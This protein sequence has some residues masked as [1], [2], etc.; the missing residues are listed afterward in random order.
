MTKSEATRQVAGPVEP[1]SA[2][3]AER[4]AP[5]CALGR[6][7]WKLRAWSVSSM[8]RSLCAGSRSER[9]DMT[10]D[11][12]LRAIGAAFGM[13]RVEASAGLWSVR[14]GTTPPCEVVL[15]PSF[16]KAHI[17]CSGMTPEELTRRIKHAPDSAWAT[18]QKPFRTLVLTVAEA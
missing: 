6:W 1:F 5:R 11:E 13:V 10:R 9:K 12:C 3:A 15:M 8:T 2:A 16:V 4:T 17:D 14:V 18:V 7:N